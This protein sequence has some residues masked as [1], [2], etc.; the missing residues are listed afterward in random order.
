MPHRQTDR[1]TDRVTLFHTLMLLN[2]LALFLTQ[3]VH[4]GPSAAVILIRERQSASALWVLEGSKP[5]KN[6]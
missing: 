6:L 2:F 3:S 1:R 5:S 4:S